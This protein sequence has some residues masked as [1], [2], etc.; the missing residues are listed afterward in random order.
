MV[1]IYYRSF[2]RES[3]YSR[4]VLYL[5]EVVLAPGTGKTFSVWRH[6]RISISGVEPS[7]LLNTPCSSI[8]NSLRGV[9][10]RIPSL[11]GFFCDADALS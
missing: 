6:C 7:R 10:W 1:Q 2:P 9:T 11:V 4:A 3:R 5:E 8:R